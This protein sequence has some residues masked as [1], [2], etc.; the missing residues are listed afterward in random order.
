[1]NN[2]ELVKQ[3]YAAFGEGNISAVLEMLD[4]NVNWRIVG[5]PDYPFFGRY[6]GHNGFQEFLGKLGGAAE[7]SSFEPQRFLDAGNAVIVTGSESATAKNT[8]IEYST[9]WC[10]I[11]TIE[12]GKVV[13]F[14][15]YLDSAPLVAAHDGGASA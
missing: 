14:E 7:I 1:M 8:N 12:G 5:P 9:E 2:I 3:I 11:F 13:S 15:E 4:Q 10:H 6:K